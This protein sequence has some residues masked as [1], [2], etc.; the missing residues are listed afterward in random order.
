[1]KIIRSL[2]L[3]IFIGAIQLFTY[4]SVMV[5]GSLS[6]YQIGL[7]NESYKGSIE[8]LNASNK[9]QEVRI[10]QTDYL[11]N[12]KGN[13]FYNEPIS[14]PRSNA[15]WIEFSSKTIILKANETQ[16]IRYEVK[17]PNNDSLRGT[18]WSVLMIEDV[19]SIDPNKKGQLNIS[20]TTRYAVKIITNIDLFCKGML[21]IM[22]P[23]VVSKNNKTFLE[24]NIEN[25]GERYISPIVKIE[26]LNEIG[27]TLKTF[28]MTKKGIFPSTSLQFLFDLKGISKEKHQVLILADGGGDDVFGLEYNLEL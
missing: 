9:E 8:I 28:E 23:E 21:H 11:Y 19:N 12:Y 13:F 18:Y 25:I 22:E 6:H 14:Q 4:G 27:E 20:T 7:P 3:L 17:I 5:V 16:F 24:I 26:I 1:M 10:Y 2:F 15:S